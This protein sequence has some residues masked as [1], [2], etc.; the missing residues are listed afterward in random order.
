MEIPRIRLMV[1]RL[2]A[3]A[4]LACSG[5]LWAQPLFPNPV[6]PVGS[7]PYGMAL[8][9]FNGDGMQDI[10]VSNYGVDPTDL[11]L[12]MGRGDGT[13]SDEVRVPTTQHADNVLAADVDQ[14]GLADLI[15]TYPSTGAAVVMPGIGDGTFGEESL[16]SDRV[17]RLHLAD[18]NDDQV[19]DLLNEALSNPPSFEA[20]IGLGDGTF[21]ASP[22]VTA[23]MPR[24]PLAADLNGDGRDDVLT[25]RT[26]PTELSPEILIFLGAGDGSFV[27]AGSLTAPDPVWAL[28]SADVDGDGWD[29]LGVQTLHPHPSGT[30]LDLLLYFSNGD[31]SFMPGPVE[32][33]AY[34][35]DIIA[36]DRNGDGL[37]DYVRIGESDVEPFLGQGGRTYTKLPSF[38][39]GSDVKRAVSG[40]FD[41]DGRL[42]LATLANFSEAVFVYAGSA[43]GSFGPPVDTTVRDSYLG[44]LVTD[45]FD[46]DGVLDMAAAVLDEDQ[47]AI[48]LGH[49]DGTF[50]VESRFDA[51]VGPVF[52]ASADMNGD[53]RP[54]LV[55]TTRNWH[56]EA[57]DP[58]PNGAV[59]VLIGN[60]DG[61][62]LPPSSYGGTFLPGNAMHVRDLDGDGVPDVL[63][64]NWTDLQQGVQPDLSYFHGN[65][66]GTLGAMVHLPAGT[67]FH[68]P[69][70]WTFP[71]GLASGDFDGD[72]LRDIVVAVSGLP[73]AGVPGTVR[74]LRGLGGGTFDDPVS[75]AETVVSADVA[76]AD[77]D[78]DGTDDIAVADAASYISLN[79]GGLYTLLNDGSGGFAQSALLPAGIGPIDVQVTDLTGDGEPDLAAFNNAGYLAILPGLG[80]GAFG[81]PISFGLFGAPLALVAGDFDGDGLSDLLVVSNSGVFVLE[82]QGQS[83][84]Q[85]QID[86]QIASNHPR[87]SG[88]S[89]LT[90]TTNAEFDLT[91]FN[92]IA[93]IGGQRRQINAAVIPCEECTSGEGHTYSLLVPM[94]YAWRSIYIE[95]VHVD[96]TI[97][98]F[99]PA[100]SRITRLRDPGRDLS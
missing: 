43:N 91:G 84:P 19:P 11:S 72:G 12:L 28:M 41:G 77:L 96:G 54:D 61:S 90:W 21:A 25:A 78:G 50:G 44:G 32:E 87:G 83:H 66:D 100:R 65:A 49:G 24:D 2:V 5:S 3:T 73:D 17:F 31:G 86:G 56:F 10:V 74:I 52:L 8:A 94:R 81:A 82:G 88:W 48:K 69:Y 4:I 51:G 58:I 46:G 45:D 85:L 67:G 62:F 59:V 97:E 20:L 71:L 57:P 68:F 30:N 64:A 37:Q 23:G 98:T 99:G 7:N 89:T 76:V 53:G 80:N 35:I 39:S 55:A 13:F 47:I 42:D 33:E 40:H 27:P 36:S 15:L 38:F 34:T 18:F 26:L 29:D 75:V 6:Y 70:G 93:L 16:I 22:A 63:V 1:S 9:D 79:P 92:A 60:G 95:A 14:D